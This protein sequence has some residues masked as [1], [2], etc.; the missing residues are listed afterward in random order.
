MYTAQSPHDHDPLQPRQDTRGP[1]PELT[2]KIPQGAGYDVFIMDLQGA[3][4]SPRP[5]M[6][7]PCNISPPQQQQLQS[8]LVPNPL[9]NGPCSPSYP[10]QLGNSQSNWDEVDTVV[11]YIIGLRRRQHVALIGHSAAAFAFGPYALQHPE[12]VA[13]LFLSA[14]VFPPRGRK[15]TGTASAYRPV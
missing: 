3:G 5:K 12:K 14:P 2:T 6:D 15:G 9:E 13:S 7:D 11:D 10:H 4:K 1:R 8:I